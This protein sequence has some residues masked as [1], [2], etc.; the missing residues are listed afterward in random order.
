[1]SSPFPSLS[2]SGLGLSGRRFRG[3]GGWD[4]KPLHPPLAAVPLGTTVA[5]VVFDLVSRLFAGPPLARELYRSATFTL[6]VGQIFIA[7][8]VLTGWWDRRRLTRKATDR[9]H[10]ANAHAW[11]MLAFGALGFCEILVRNV[12]YHDAR[13]TPLAVLAMTIGLGGLAVLGGTLG[14]A[15]TFEHGLAVE[16]T[17][18][19]AA[20][21]SH[22]ART[23]ALDEPAG[24]IPEGTRA[25]SSGSVVTTHRPRVD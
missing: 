24:A 8:A 6:I 11:L 9:R 1:M 19:T 3:L 14:G 13:H 18:E 7:L 15:L 25:M 17:K 20:Q 5:T 23:D 4:G 16:R 12:A 2:F 10:S 22:G 21:S